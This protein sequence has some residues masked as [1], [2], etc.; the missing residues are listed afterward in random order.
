MVR[1]FV[2]YLDVF[3][4]IPS[5][6]A[7]SMTVAVLGAVAAWGIGESLRAAAAVTVLEVLGLLY[8]CFVARDSLARLPGEWTTLLPSPTAAGLV[9][10]LSGAFIAFYAF[11][12]FED[13]ANIAEEVEAPRLNLPRGILIALCASTLLYFLVA[14]VAVLAV[15]HG[16]LA[17]SE[18]PLALI[19]QTRGI[20]PAT[21]AGI[22]LFAVT[23]GALIQIIMTSRVL[24]G[25]AQQRQ[26]PAVFARVHPRTRTP[27]IGT[28]LV[29]AV[30][31]ALALFFT[32]GGLA[33]ATSFIALGIF[34]CVNAALW[35]MKRSG[36]RADG[37]SVPI[38]VPATGFALCVAM[39]V[40]EALSSV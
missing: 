18:A 8:V 34:A 24:Y 12:G 10:V 20:P 11:I 28:A 38:G 31:M 19:V 1:G 4:S 37:F 26:A 23:N 17:G 21:I 29:S 27:L 39:I 25:L 22:S 36:I 2:G 7:I 3:V 9:G 15:P 33:R 32:L 40:Y 13:M 14:T 16:E 35:R 30:L 5:W 6:L